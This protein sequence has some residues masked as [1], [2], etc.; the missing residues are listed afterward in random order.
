MDTKSLSSRQMHLA[1]E[2][3]WYYFQIDYRQSKANAAADA[4]LHFSPRNQSKED[5]FYTENTQIFYW[6]QTLLIDV[7]LSDLNLVSPEC[8]LL[9]LHQVFIC[10][11][12]IISLLYRFWKM[13]RGN[14]ANKRLYRTIIGGM[15]LRFPKL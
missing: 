4:L 14:L 9:P 12:H 6:L 13:L 5:A 3:F 2:L 1:Q 7:Y 10:G 11:T 8:R 15:R